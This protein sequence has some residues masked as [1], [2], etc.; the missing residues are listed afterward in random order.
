MI[1]STRETESPTDS[2]ANIVRNGEAGQSRRPD[3]QFAGAAT[4]FRTR[5]VSWEYLSHYAQT[6]RTVEVRGNMWLH[7]FW[8]ERAL[9]A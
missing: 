7:S 2:L 9:P 5:F 6:F 8:V 1:V 4:V 3:K